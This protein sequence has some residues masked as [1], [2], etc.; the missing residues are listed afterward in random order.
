MQ[1]RYLDAARTFNTILTFIH[2]C[3]ALSLYTSFSCLSSTVL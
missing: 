3:A 1:K 2:R